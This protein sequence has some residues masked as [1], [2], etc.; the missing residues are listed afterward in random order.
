MAAWHSIWTS[1]PECRAVCDFA[2]SAVKRLDYHYL[3]AI[4][5]LT[6]ILIA[7]A[8]V[9]K[10]FDKFKVYVADT[11]RKDSTYLDIVFNKLKVHGVNTSG[12]QDVQFFTL[13]IFLANGFLHAARIADFQILTSTPLRSFSRIT[14]FQIIYLLTNAILWLWAIGKYNQDV[15]IKE[16]VYGIN[17]E[18]LLKKQKATVLAYFSFV[19]ALFVF[20]DALSKY[21]ELLYTN[22]ILAYLLGGF[23]TLHGWSVIVVLFAVSAIALFGLVVAIKFR[24]WASDKAWRLLLGVIRFYVPFTAVLIGI[25]T[26]AFFMYGRHGNSIVS[27][28]MQS[29]TPVQSAIPAEGVASVQPVPS[30]P[31]AAALQPAASAQSFAPEQ[32]PILAEG[33]DEHVVADQTQAIQVDPKDKFAYNARG[34]ANNTKG[35][36]DGAIRDFSAAIRL[37]PKYALAYNNRCLA[38]NNKGERDLALAD[39]NEA[40]RLDPKFTS[41]YVNRGIVSL[42]ESSLPMALADFNQWS[43]LDPKSAYAICRAVSPRPPSKST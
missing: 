41:A 42:Y 43:Q 13:A 39:C 1:F 19:T 37:D 22:D 28:S 33:D 29:D 23:Q 3:A 27:A 32:R 17:D 6:I 9:F 24:D 12:A 35:D 30:A 25:G 15:K 11:G 40:I 16:P 5:Y 4:I 26:L 7:A 2:E 20:D 34:L 14:V 21:W 38:R 36:F 31:S 10:L 18:A 8:T